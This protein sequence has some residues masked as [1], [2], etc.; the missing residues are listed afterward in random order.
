MPAE[1]C[2]GSAMTSGWDEEV[3]ELLA[4]KSPAE[5]AEIVLGLQTQIRELED[6]IEETRIWLSGHSTGANDPEAIAMWM[7]AGKPEGHRHG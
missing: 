5:L 7:L 1:S 4:L 2:E 6:S 3:R